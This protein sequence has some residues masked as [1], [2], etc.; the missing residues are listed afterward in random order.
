MSKTYCGKSCEECREAAELQCGGCETGPG[1]PVS[2]D[3]RIAICCRSNRKERCGA[4][5]ERSGCSMLRDKYNAPANRIKKAGAEEARKI[6]LSRR[7]VMPGKW[8]WPLFWL[9]IPGIVG[10]ILSNDTITGWFPGLYLP[11]AVLSLAV[12]LIYGIILIRLSA[13]EGRYFT[14]GGFTVVTVLLNAVALV[15]SFSE[16]DDVLSTIIAIPVVVLSMLSEYNEYSAHAS[17]TGDFNYELASRWRVLLKWYMAAMITMIASLV[18]MIA[19][20]VI[21]LLAM[22]AASIGLLIVNV[23]KLYYL[24]KT[25]VLFRAY[26]K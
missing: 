1:R 14:A 2:G 23:V 15:V 4:C 8:L 25:A 11:G 6:E 21:G 5:S 24:Y 18:V 26:G 20:P 19:V 17:L 3:C 13:V 22:L 10:N 12:N 16:A 7:A 9:I